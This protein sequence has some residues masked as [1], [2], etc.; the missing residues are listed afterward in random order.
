[1]FCFFNSQQN[2][3]RSVLILILAAKLVKDF[4]FVFAPKHI[5]FYLLNMLFQDKHINNIAYYI[6]DVPLMSY[7]QMFSM[8]GLP[9]VPIIMGLTIALT[10]A[11]G[12]T[13]TQGIRSW[14]LS[15]IQHCYVGFLIDD[16]IIHYLILLWGPM[17][18]SYIR[19]NNKGD[20]VKHRSLFTFLMPKGPLCGA[21]S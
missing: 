18:S 9:T 4:T 21:R 7:L 19:A 6:I 16:A 11:M 15:A 8:L 3:R 13:H 17:D 1:M 12:P 20:R 14:W 5:L 2:C 10:A